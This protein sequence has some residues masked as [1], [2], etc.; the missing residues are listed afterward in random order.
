MVD[1]LHIFYSN[2]LKMY[3]KG[4]ADFTRGGC[5]VS[6]SRDVFHTN[7]PYNLDLA[8]ILFFT[9]LSLLFLSSATSAID[10]SF[11]AGA[12]LTSCLTEHW[13]LTDAFIK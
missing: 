13:S 2:Y 12:F 8:V 4:H 6:G 11:P 7:I 9:F 5:V 1:E 3:I 10:R